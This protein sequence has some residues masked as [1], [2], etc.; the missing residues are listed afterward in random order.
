MW[1]LKN[2]K[3]NDDNNNNKTKYILT[4]ILVILEI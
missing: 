3:P 1:K 4:K 2:G